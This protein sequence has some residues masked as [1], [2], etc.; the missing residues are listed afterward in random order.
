M[1]YALTMPDFKPSENLITDAGVSLNSDEVSAYDAPY[2]AAEY[3]TAIRAL[4][5][6]ASLINEERALKAWEK[7]KNFD[8]PF[9]TLVGEFDTLVGS[10]R[11]QNKLMNNIQGAKGHPHDR[12]PGGHFIQES[13]GE[14]M[15]QR[16]VKFIESQV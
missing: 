11:I 2:P 7:I 14:E 5:S 3:R 6:M 16:L 1:E 15:A 10:K 13:L 4:P 9:L 12:L 8:K